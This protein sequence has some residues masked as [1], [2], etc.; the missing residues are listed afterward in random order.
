MHAGLRFRR[1]RSGFAVLFT[2]F[3]LT[4][5]GIASAQT[6]QPFVPE[7]NWY[8][9]DWGLGIVV[10]GLGNLQVET[11][12]VPGI[13]SA[14]HT[15]PIPADAD[16][17]LSPIRNYRL[18]PSRRHVIIS[19]GTSDFTATRIYVYRIPAADGAALIPL[20]RSIDFASGV[21]PEHFFDDGA[22]GQ[23]DFLHAV[24]I[25]N[26]LPT[27]RIW[28]LNLETGAGGY[29]VDVPRI[30]DSPVYY[31]PNGIAA[32]IKHSGTLPGTSTYLT[33]ALCDDSIGM[34]Y[35][36]TG[37]FMQ[38]LPPPVAN[39][40]LAGDAINGWSAELEHD[41][42]ILEF[43]PLDDCVG[44][45]S[46]PTGAG[47][48]AGVC[49]PD[50][51]EAACLALGGTWQ[52]AG[53]TCAGVD[54]PPPP[55]PQLALTISAP[56]AVQIGQPIEYTLQ[57]QN[58]GN[59]TAAATLLRL[60]LPA[61]VAFGSASSPGILESN[62]GWASWELGDLAA[63]A[64]VTHT[65][66]VIPDCATTSATLSFSFVRSGLL[67]SYGNVVTTTVSQP[68]GSLTASVSA[69]PSLV[70][71]RAGETIDYTFTLLSVGSD[72]QDVEFFGQYGDHVDLDAFGAAG[73]GV[74]QDN[75]GVAFHWIG[76]LRDGVPEQLTLRVRVTDCYAPSPPTTN[77]NHGYDLQIY[78]P[79]SALISQMTPPPG[80]PMAVRDIV[81]SVVATGPGDVRDYGG[82]PFAGAVVRPGEPFPVVWRIT[83]IGP[84]GLTIDSAVCSLGQLLPAN[85][86]PFTETPPA[87][88][89]WNASSNSIV[90]TGSLAPGDSVSIRFE[91]ECPPDPP[92][93]LGL[94]SQV[95]TSSCP[96]Y[97]SGSCPVVGVERPW[98]EAHL[99]IGHTPRRIG[100]FRPG[101]DTEEQPWF[102]LGIE[103]GALTS[104]A[105]GGAIWWF[106]LMTWRLDPETLD[107]WNFGES[108]LQQHG[109]LALHSVAEDS[110][111]IVYF[112]TAVD[113]GGQN[114]TSIMRWDPATDTSSLLW[115][116]QTG[117]VGDISAI[118]S[119]RLDG[120]TELAGLTS[121]GLLKMD[122]N[123]PASAVLWSD[124]TVLWPLRMT[125]L[126][127]GGDYVVDQLVF[128]LTTP[129]PLISIDP[130]D[131]T[132]DVLIADLNAMPGADTNPYFSMTAD[133]SSRIYLA[134]GFGRLVRVDPAMQP[135]V[136][137]VVFGGITDNYSGLIWRSGST[138]PTG[139]GDATPSAH[140]LVLSG[141]APNPFNPR[142]D[143]RFEVPQAGRVRLELFDV[144]GRRV[145][146]L[147]DA[148]LPAGE[149]RTEWNGRD[150][151]GREVPSGVYLARLR[152][153]QG[154]V[155]TKLMLAR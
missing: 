63:G 129:E 20:G 33:I 139:V 8:T 116:E 6:G 131:G 142:T 2:L 18:S 100:R 101:V 46:P 144:R 104:V 52:G 15:H 64:S 10:D 35:S 34:P 48:V 83:N 120:D 51:T 59:G 133:D 102:C 88:T 73:S 9:D 85:D 99:L 98:S 112:A 42:S 140:R 80:I 119:L 65:L 151:N 89:L 77:L 14:D 106:G 148:E 79:C 57:V 141:A 76:D 45:V 137:T 136:P 17:G 71:L 92:C 86:P 69:A 146:R 47:C 110:T 54:C 25:G 84:L 22:G 32:F 72:R 58:A 38:D 30:V 70:P 41:G 111:G 128:G 53:S 12:G 60:A 103:T 149:H 81:T 75:S 123:D 11:D 127:D 68:G 78:G 154:T 82:F 145:A 96:N 91:A 130:I 147:V 61:G 117:N 55:Q 24:S 74:W 118:S 126:P 44:A 56:S 122:V 155:T 114:L 26:I 31:A 67:V 138:A 124:P 132:H 93:G 36:V 4:L 135:L 27:Q 107:F 28:W 49:V 115:Q 16:A 5:A 150:G 113:A 108:F 62:G 109:M 90:W 143:L 21:N 37:G 95:S 105:P 153:A 40:F 3:G 23:P 50:L 1:T 94:T 125:R 43:F 134:P 13:T 97:A 19:G 29:T 121:E 152:T 66:I 87:G 7:Q 39:A